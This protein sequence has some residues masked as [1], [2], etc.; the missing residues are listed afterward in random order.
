M[1]TYTN[2]E[3]N[4][5]G[6]GL[7]SISGFD[8]QGAGNNLD[9]VT[10]KE[11]NLGESLLTPGLQTAV[12]CQNSIYIPPGKDFDSFKN[13]A[14]SFSLSCKDK[15]SLPVNQKIYRL[16]NR[17]WLPTNVGQTEEFILHACDETQMEDARKLVSQSWKCSSPSRIAQEILGT[18]AGA[19]NMQIE[20]ADNERDY[21]AENIHPFQVIAQQTNVALANGNDPSFLHFM[22]YGDDGGIHHFESLNKLCNGAI[23][24]TFV[25]GET[26]MAGDGNYDNQNSIISFSFPC[27][28]DYLSDLLNGLE[29]GKNMNT[30]GIVNFT[31]K[32]FSQ[33]GSSD[34]SCGGIGGFNYKQALSNQATAEDQDSCNLD[35]ENHLLR[36][37]ARM[38]LL[39]KDK[40]ALRM[41]VPWNPKL[42]AGV[43]I[44]FDW[45]N[46]HQPN[47]PVY[48]SGKY[49]VLSMMHTIRLGGFSTTTIECVSTT[50]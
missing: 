41:V 26:G 33:L 47:P 8:I 35:V 50:V 44:K 18:C 4:A 40:I 32:A 7:V 48:G 38:S 49:L 39:E 24:E 11:I 14:I 9:Q 21:I 22:T 25:H 19:K 6:R 27:D 46:K 16:D 15:G 42:H 28:F 12:V 43:V 17:E 30:L 13:K 2:I 20:Q 36:R 23:V 1:A 34:M 31:A 29:D 5:S 3:S 45:K 10:I 37:Q